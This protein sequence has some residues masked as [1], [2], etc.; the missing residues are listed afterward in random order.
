MRLEDAQSTIREVHGKSY[1]WLK[2]WGLGTVRE[3]IRTI[4]DRKSATDADIELAEDVE[5]R[6][7]R[8]W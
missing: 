2:A 8:R 4:Y 6:I 5:R 1:T 7:Y 3:A